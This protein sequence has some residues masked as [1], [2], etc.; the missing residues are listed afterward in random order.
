MIRRIREL[1]WMN[2]KREREERKNNIIIKGV[3][4]ENGI[5]AQK[6]CEYIKENLKIEVGVKRAYKV[7]TKEN[8]SIVCASLDSWEQKKEIIKKKK[9]LKQEIKWIEDDLTKEER[10]IQK[11]T[12]RDDESREE[13]R[14]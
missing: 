2:E 4:W 10:K 7:K 12:K 14:K 6:V 8:K 1:E 11:K 5:I 3:G 13:E 9:E